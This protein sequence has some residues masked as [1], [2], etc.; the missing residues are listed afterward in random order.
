MGE[1]RNKRPGNLGANTV[2]KASTST[3]E[4]KRI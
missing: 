3:H 4:A 1:G 2:E